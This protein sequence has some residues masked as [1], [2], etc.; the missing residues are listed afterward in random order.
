MLLVGLAVM[1]L[2]ATFG[3]LKGGTLVRLAETRFRGLLFLASAAALQV[4]TVLLLPPESAAT[5]SRL[6]LAS[7]LL[8]GACLFLNRRLPGV[9]V[10]GVGLALNATV[11]FLNGGMPTS[12]TAAEIASIDRDVSRLDAEH[13]SMGPETRLKP[14]SDIIPIPRGHL[15]ISVGD[16]LLLVGL[17]RFVYRGTQPPSAHRKS[18]G[19]GLEISVEGGET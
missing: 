3:L 12:Q 13:V 6:L 1:L 18:T 10:A 9:V 8:A 2:A 17:A 4:A 14:L 11:I 15:V 19:F 16:V 5:A 7:N